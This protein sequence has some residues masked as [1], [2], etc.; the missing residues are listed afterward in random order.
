M[1]KKSHGLL[2]L[3]FARLWQYRKRCRFCKPLLLQER[4]GILLLNIPSAFSYVPPE[5]QKPLIGSDLI[6]PL[7]CSYLQEHQ[8]H[9]F[10]VCCSFYLLVVIA[11]KIRMNNVMRYYN[12]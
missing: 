6:K 12:L 5:Y 4:L 1:S 11:A 7:A 8:N 9:L 10:E 3:S 2:Y